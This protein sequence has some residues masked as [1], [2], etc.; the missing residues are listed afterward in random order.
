MSTDP[1]IPRP[2]V[3]KALQVTWLLKG[4]LKNSQLAY[5]RVGALLARVRDE[6]LYAALKHAD[7]ESYAEQRL[8]L[9]R[10][11]LYRYLQVYAWVTSSHPEWL[12]PKPKGFI[13]SLADAAGLIWIES[14]LA[15]RRLDPARRAAL[16]VLRQ[17]GLDGSL[18]KKDLNDFRRKGRT[19]DASLKAYLSTLRQVRRRGESI[20]G[21][22][23]EV[24][25]HLDSA[26]EILAHDHTLKLA[27]LGEMLKRAVG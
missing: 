7:I 3:Q 26:I 12:Q 14:T 15:G 22:P 2:L 4:H 8:H 20:K 10:T 25:S 24:L 18:S 1:K 21:L 5:L 27:G 19:G 23:V 13:P 16:E 17:K 6:K 9:G 11:S